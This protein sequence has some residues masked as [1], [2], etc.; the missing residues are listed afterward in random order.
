M[1]RANS[2]IEEE[3]KLL[4]RLVELQGDKFHGTITIH[5]ADGVPKKKELKAVYDIK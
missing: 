4:K 3:K 5:C 1:V 2:N